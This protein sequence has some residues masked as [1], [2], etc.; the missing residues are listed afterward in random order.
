MI[1]LEALFTPSGPGEYT[2]RVSQNCALLSAK[3]Y[4]VDGRQE[5][6]EF[7]KKCLLAEGSYSMDK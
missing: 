3:D 2:F 4:D 7:L 1:A 6:F 5:V